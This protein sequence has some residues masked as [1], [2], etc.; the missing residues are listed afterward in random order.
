LPSIATHGGF[1]EIIGGRE[2]KVS[3]LEELKHLLSLIYFKK[4]SCLI[5]NSGSLVGY[6]T[7]VY[8]RNSLYPHTRGS[9]I[10]PH[11]RGSMVIGWYLSF[12]RR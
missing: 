8:R 4:S 9:I 3:G 1:L 12:S 2:L 6:R 7:W 10:H 11:T 5:S